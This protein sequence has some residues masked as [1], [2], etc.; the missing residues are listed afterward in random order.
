MVKFD[1]F[2]DIIFNDD[3]KQ[4]RLI[5]ALQSYNYEVSNFESA[6]QLLY[7]KVS[8]RDLQLILAPFLRELAIERL[9]HSDTQHCVEFRNSF[10]RSD[11]S[12]LDMEGF[13][14]RQAQNKIWAMAD[15]AVALAEVLGV[16]L[17][18]SYCGSNASGDHLPLEG[19]EPHYCHRAEPLTDDSVHLYFMPDEHYFAYHNGYAKTIGDGNCLYNGFAQ[20]LQQF[21]AFENRK[22]DEVEYS[23][24][25]IHQIYLNQQKVYNKI[26][27]DKLSPLSFEKLR[28]LNELLLKRSEIKRMCLEELEKDKATSVSEEKDVPTKVDYSKAFIK[29]ILHQINLVC[30]DLLTTFNGF[31]AVALGAVVG[32]IVAVLTILTTALPVTA[33]IGAGLFVG[34]SALAG[35]F[36]TMKYNQQES[37][38]PNDNVE[39]EV[40]TSSP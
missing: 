38:E 25:E 22:E 10:P 8:E 24:D 11:D 7:S 32:V 30:R 2:K 23:D 13:L 4:A 14:Q 33:A 34:V 19:W 20:Y 6:H 1:R 5:A 35:G 36:F 40:I 39:K 28:E 18:M 26:K 12:T 27:G 37:V 3:E 16:N 17:V 9:R 29:D 21:V 15:E 31:F